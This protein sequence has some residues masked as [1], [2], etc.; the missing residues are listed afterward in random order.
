M[1]AL[2]LMAVF[3]VCLVPS[4]FAMN[5]SYGECAF[6]DNT[7][8]CAPVMNNATVV[9]S[10]ISYENCSQMFYDNASVYAQN[11][12]TYCAQANAKMDVLSDRITA[13]FSNTYGNLTPSFITDVIDCRNSNKAM[14]TQLDALGGVQANLTTCNGALSNL[15]PYQNSSQY[16]NNLYTTASQNTTTYAIVAFIAGVAI[17]FAYYRRKNA[18]FE[19]DDNPVV[20]EKKVLPPDL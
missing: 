11:A 9:Y 3:A 14:S 16:W 18:S 2:I 4:V 1:K 15:Q 7:T 8:I 13:T 10:N 17:V 5:L 12:T 6:I 19:G 20:H